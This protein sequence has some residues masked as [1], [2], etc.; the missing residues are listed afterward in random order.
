MKIVGYYQIDIEIKKDWFGIIFSMC[1]GALEIVAGCILF[2]Y[3]DGVFGTEL[4]EE[5]YNDIKFGV[6]C[7]IGKREF[8]WSEFK[9]KKLIR[10]GKKKKRLYQ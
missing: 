3:T 7:I 8:S 4:I 2:C 1:I 9:K 6:E 10:K 5:G